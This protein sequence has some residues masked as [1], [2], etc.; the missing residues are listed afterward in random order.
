MHK[1][2]DSATQVL[3]PCEPYI[4]DGFA[5]TV[6][7]ADKPEPELQEEITITSPSSNISANFTL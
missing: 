3:V 7:V 5:Y 2:Y 4:E 6:Q 1:P